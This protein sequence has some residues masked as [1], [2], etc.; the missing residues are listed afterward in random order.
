M[1]A[2]KA[3]L[4]F[5]T[6]F[7]RS[8]VQKERP[9]R[10]YRFMNLIHGIWENKVHCQSQ[11]GTKARFMRVFLFYFWFLWK[12]VEMPSPLSSHL[13]WS[14]CTPFESGQ[15]VAMRKTA[16]F[17]VWPRLRP[18]TAG[19][20][21]S[22]PRGPECRRSNDGK[23]DGIN[24]KGVFLTVLGHFSCLLG[25]MVTLHTD[26]KFCWPDFIPSF[27]CCLKIKCPLIQF[28]S[29]ELQTRVTF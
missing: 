6:K 7:G 10:G 18:K 28:H 12:P 3:K 9:C 19:I 25:L 22:N 24:L 11:H 15:R 4:P 14:W 17:Q 21:H 23:W 2:K 20:G 27:I 5:D 26:F 13:G 8:T 29:I 1:Q 16:N